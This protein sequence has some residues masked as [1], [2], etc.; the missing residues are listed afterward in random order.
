[1]D[2]TFFKNSTTEKPALR[3]GLLLDSTTLSKFFAEIVD[4]IEQS[5]FAK[6][7]L[8]IFNQEAIEQDAAPPPRR[9]L[10]RKIIDT[11]RDAKSRRT[12]FFNLYQRWDVR[13]EEP[14]TNPD[15][16]ADFA[17]RLAHVTSMHVAPITKRFVHRL[18]DDAVAQ[19]RE[20]KLDVLIRFGFNILRGDVLTAAKYG[21]WS[22]HHGDNDYYRGGPANFWEVLERNPMSGAILQ[23]LTEELDA[24]KVMCKGLFATDVGFSHARNRVQPFW[25]SVTF[26]IQKLQ[27][28][29]MRGWE[30]VEKNMLPI[31]PY[32]GKKKIYSAPTNWEMFRW[33]V[34][35]LAGKVVRR[36][37][38]QETI[39][40]WR[41]ALRVGGPP[42]V[43]SASVPDLR[44]FQWIDSP[45]GRFYADPFVVEENGKHWIFFEDFDYATK[46]GRISCAEVRDG[47]LGPVLTA[48]DRPYHLSYPCVFF[49]GGKWYMIPESAAAGTVELYRC[50]RFPDTWQLERVLLRTPAVDSTIWIENGVYWLFVTLQESRGA[51]YQLWLFSAGTLGE[52]WAAHP[53]NPISTD[54]RYARGAGEIF[55]HEGRLFRPS[56]DCSG[57]YGRCTTINEIVVMDSDRYVELPHT[58]IAPEQFENLVG[59]HTYNRK[60]AVEVIDGKAHY[61][62]HQVL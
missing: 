18:P 51:A 38:A 13:N 43:T 29:H 33:L 55:R 11:L 20:K 46:I 7:E 2:P 40:H 53:A 9:S 44:G 28:L 3:I 32:L 30:H 16:P 60:G 61:P 21:V 22:Y 12:I 48:L 4:H 27:E 8:L 26:M 54:V 25:G 57:E 45:K 35:L 59:T 1:M 6:I 39:R 49:D 42:I 58:V 19:I 5:N 56:Q 17:E 41:M 14:S 23:V 15:T 52:T 36:L 37:V 10:L 34:P 50:S 47:G 31:A 24:G 62:L